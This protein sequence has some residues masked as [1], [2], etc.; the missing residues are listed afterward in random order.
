[1]KQY[2]FIFFLSAAI[3]SVSTSCSEVGPFIDFTPV[4]ETLID[5]TYTTDSIFTAQSK[6]VLLED[7]TGQ[8]CPNCPAAHDII[9][10]IVAEHGD[11]VAAI[12]MYNYFAD[13][14]EDLEFVTDQ[15]IDLG[16]YLGPVIGWPTGAVDRKNFGSGILVLKDL[17]ASHVDA[18]MLVSPPCNVSISTTYDDAINKLNIL[19]GVKY[20]SDV[21]TINHL[22]VAICENN[23]IALQ[24]DA[25]EEIPD[26]IH[27]H[28]LRTMLTAATGNV[29]SETN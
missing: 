28:V 19:V 16:T 11:A 23:I 17:Y 29:L 14:S 25:T 26:Y 7:F 20:L 22:S 12:A 21:T 3:I 9:N 10:E 24:V 4:D 2:F 5:T 1:M 15:A 18:Q 8:L 6:V 13:I 27:N